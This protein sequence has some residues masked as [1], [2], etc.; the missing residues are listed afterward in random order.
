M[1][2]E[3][4]TCRGR[5]RR[6]IAPGYWECRSQRLV[7][8]QG[9]GTMQTPIFETCFV[10]YQEADALMSVAK[11][12]CGTFAIGICAR[13][14]SPVCGDC[15][16][17]YGGRRLCRGCLGMA[18]QA[19]RQAEQDAARTKKRKEEQDRADRLRRLE[20]AVAAARSSL[21]QRGVPTEQV[22]TLATRSF[23]SSGG[24]SGHAYET[25]EPYFYIERELGSGWL[26]TS[27][28]VLLDQGVLCET[29]S[30]GMLTSVHDRS[31]WSPKRELRLAAR[32]PIKLQALEISRP[33]NEIEPLISALEAIVEGGKPVD[34]IA[35]SVV[36]SPR[37]NK[38]T[39]TRS[40]W[41]LWLLVVPG[42]YPGLVGIVGQ[43]IHGFE[44][45]GLAHAMYIVF[46]VTI[47]FVL[48]MALRR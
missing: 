14:D 23:H 2:G 22:A 20:A 4:P 6:Q 28:F 16:A 45:S 32:A 41:Y 26:V 31:R 44:S 43:S 18:R 19:E 30:G 39:N 3:C 21:K 29:G 15:S 42:F 47:L 33:P 9:Y 10:R 48:I 36:W 27:E 25:R 38:P 11:C 24:L 35:D 40:R 46:P 34:I 13:C 37:G 17:I 12:S 1:A 8:M 5:E 7:G